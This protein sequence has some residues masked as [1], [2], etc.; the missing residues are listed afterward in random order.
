[1]ALIAPAL[2]AHTMSDSE[3]AQPGDLLKVTP[4][5]YWP[6]RLWTPDYWAPAARDYQWVQPA[7]PLADRPTVE[8][9]VSLD[10]T[11]GEVLEAACDFWGFVEGP[12]MKKMGVVRRSEF[13][14]FGFVRVPEDEDGVD[15]QVDHK[16][17]NQLPAV[18]KDGSVEPVPALDITFRELLVSSSFGLIPGDVTRPYVYPVPPQGVLTALG[19]LA[20]LSADAVQAVY[21]GL[22]SLGH[23]AAHTLHRLT[24]E[25]TKADQ[26]ILN[27]SGN[28]GLFV[29]I[30]K[31]LRD[32]HK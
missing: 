32:R 22:D 4:V 12:H 16:W 18:R 31:W 21:A 23:E 6:P 15:E 28:V 30:R 13:H 19:D 14:R 2:Y 10:V 3:L 11:L 9:E 1:M 17:P 25:L 20:H 5:L 27:V 24:P 7:T 8:F 29:T 26:E